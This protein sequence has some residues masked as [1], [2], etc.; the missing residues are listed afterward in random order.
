MLDIQS[1]EYTKLVEE[2][3]YYELVLL[4]TLGFEV[5]V[6][7]PHPH[8]VKCMQFLKASKDLAQMAY[9]MAHNRCAI[10]SNVLSSS[11]PPSPLQC[12]PMWHCGLACYSMLA[13]VPVAI[14]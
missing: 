3:T 10:C 14:S 1:E 8:V 4:E 9:F 6:D 2:I 7:H 11:L 13:S 5:K 12:M